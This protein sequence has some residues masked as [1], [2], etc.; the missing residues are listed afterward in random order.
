MSIR[1]AITVSLATLLLAVPAF[2]DMA[3]IEEAIEFERLDARVTGEGRGLIE[4]VACDHCDVKRLKLTPSTTL[5]LAGRRLPLSTINNGPLFA[6][7]LFYKAGG[8]Q[9]TRIVAS[10]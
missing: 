4:L 6:G 9:V 1:H 3:L 2:A 8:D 7:T 10:Q 5:V